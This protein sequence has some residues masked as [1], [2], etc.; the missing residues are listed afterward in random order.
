MLELRYFI[1]Q[2]EPLEH[3]IGEHPPAR[4]EANEIFVV[5]HKST[6]NQFCNR[7]AK[8]LDRLLTELGG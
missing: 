4:S 3:F 6:L 8:I 1:R 7:A 2:N 5:L